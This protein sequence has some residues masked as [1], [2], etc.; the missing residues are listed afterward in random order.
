M[1]AIVRVTFGALNPFGG[2]TLV[3]T[4]A[5]EEGAITFGQVRF[6]LHFNKRHLM[7]CSQTA[8]VIAAEVGP[9]LL[10]IVGGHLRSTEAHLSTH[11][12]HRHS[13]FAPIFAWFR[14]ILPWFPSISV[15]QH[16][17]GEHAGYTLKHENVGHI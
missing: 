12:C 14:L 9:G 7:I 1:F 4:W 13:N 6:G 17:P 16:A 10:A 5:A 15:C 3:T 8:L 11:K 2:D